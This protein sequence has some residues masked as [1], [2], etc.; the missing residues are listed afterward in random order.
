[1]AEGFK[2]MFN[3]GDKKKKK[4]PEAVEPRRIRQFKPA[5]S[6][7]FIDILEED[8]A[9]EEYKFGMPLS[10]REALSADKV[11]EDEMIMVDE[12]EEQKLSESSGRKDSTDASE[13]SLLR[14]VAKDDK[15][16]PKFPHLGKYVRVNRRRGNETRIGP[17][18][19]PSFDEEDP[20]ES[21]VGS[22]FEDEL[23]KSYQAM[24]EGADDMKKSMTEAFE[25]SKGNASK[26]GDKI[27]ESADKMAASTSKAL[28]NW[29]SKI[30]S[31]FD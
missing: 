30:S 19:A 24:S 2:T 4:S 14:A 7:S 13:S 3:F 5:I 18:S 25:K 6:K 8:G 29:G 27:A 20:D 1:M 23:S 22:K 28:K 11:A 17:M 9:I 15:F 31:F 12:E 10:Q 26:M 16:K 21:L